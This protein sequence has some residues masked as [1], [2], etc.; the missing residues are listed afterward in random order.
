M[1]IRLDEEGGGKML[2]VHV[3]GTL[4]KEDYAHFVPEFER[5]LREHGKLRLLFDMTG[6]QGWEAGAAWEDLKFGVKHFADIERLAMVGDKKWQQG[7]AMFCKPFTKAAVRY[8]DHAD[9]AGA[10]KWLSET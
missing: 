6:L 3:S 7:M 1:P 8:F 4:V 10:R 5:L 9:A 2:V